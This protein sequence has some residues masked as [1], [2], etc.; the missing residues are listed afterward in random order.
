MQTRM[1]QSKVHFR[2]VSCTSAQQDGVGVGK[3]A[4]SNVDVGFNSDEVRHGAVSQLTITRGA[5]PTKSLWVVKILMAPSVFTTSLDSDGS[6]SLHMITWLS[7][8]LLSSSTAKSIWSTS[9]RLLSG[10]SG[11]QEELQ[12]CKYLV[13]LKWECKSSKQHNVVSSSSR[14]RHLVG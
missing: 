14:Y 3:A 2:I 9:S 5:R 13:F 6:S 8:G 12:I 4:V 11:K 1:D 10:L 7:R